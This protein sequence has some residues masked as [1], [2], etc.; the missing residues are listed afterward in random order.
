MPTTLMLMKNPSIKG[1]VRDMLP[2]YG[3]QHYP[4]TNPTLKYDFHFTKAG[5]WFYINSFDEG[6]LRSSEV[7]QQKK[8][9]EKEKEQ[10]RIIDTTT[11]EIIETNKPKKKMKKKNNGNA[12]IPIMVT[13]GAI[14]IAIVMM[15]AGFITISNSEIRLRNTITAKQQDNKSELD[16]MVKKIMQSGQVSQEQAKQVASVVTGYAEARATGGPANQGAGG[17]INA[18]AESVPSLPDGFFDVNRNLQNIITSSRDSFTQRQKEILDLKREH[19]N[20]ITTFPSSLVV[21]ARGK[22]E[23]Q[24]VTSARADESFET[25]QD[26]DTKLFQ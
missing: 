13:L 23:V 25:G 4:R 6:K 26:N 16:N 20:M 14:T 7:S 12:I 8:T 22:I 1:D 17:F 15:A 9:V 11:S 24:I 5:E 21:G 2:P 3:L 18:V 10:W 19:D